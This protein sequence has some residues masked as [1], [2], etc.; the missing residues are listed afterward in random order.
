MREWHKV[1]ALGD[2]VY[3]PTSQNIGT[4]VYHRAGEDLEM[5]VKLAE[6]YLYEGMDKRSICAHNAQVCSRHECTSLLS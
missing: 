2:P 6:G 4:V 3:L 5:F 1:K